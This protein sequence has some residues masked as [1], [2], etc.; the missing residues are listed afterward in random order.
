MKIKHLHHKK[1]LS[2]A[3]FSLLLVVVGTKNAFAQ[4]ESHARDIQSGPYFVGAWAS[5]TAGGTVSGGGSYSFGDRCY[6]NAT[7][8]PGYTFQYWK[9]A[10][11]DC[12]HPIVSQE[13]SYTVDIGTN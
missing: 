7:A 10:D 11:P 2:V 1:V 5:P 12:S 8:N 3:F 6:L 13:A 4:H 9:C